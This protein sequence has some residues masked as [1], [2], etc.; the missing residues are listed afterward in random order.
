MKSE[1]SVPNEVSD[2][3]T[4]GRSIASTT[5]KEKAKQG[6]IVRSVFLDR[7]PAELSL[8]VDRMDHAPRS[9]MAKIAAD[10]ERRR[11]PSRPFHGWALIRAS[12][13]ARNGRTVAATCK[14]GN[15][16][17]SDICLNIKDRDRDK[18]LRLKKE[19]ALELASLSGWEKAPQ[20]ASKAS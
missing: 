16:Y 12:D 3:E 9:E 6:V 7:R 18:Q 10:R 19:H 8:S 4:L 2:D 20:P 15:P 11:R 14:S 1:I 5:E 17:H 13:A